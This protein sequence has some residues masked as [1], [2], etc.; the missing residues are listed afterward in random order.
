MQDNQNGEVIFMLIGLFCICVE[1]WLALFSD[2]LAF[3][4][5]GLTE[6]WARF[7]WTRRWQKVW[8]HK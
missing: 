4:W 7:F 6:E 2:D 3:Y 8:G 1:D 5:A